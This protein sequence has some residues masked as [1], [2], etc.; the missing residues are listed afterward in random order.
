MIFR[1]WR[2]LWGKSIRRELVT[3][4]ALIYL[5]SMGLYAAQVGSRQRTFLREKASSRTEVQAT[6][7]ATAC[8][9]GVM[10]NDLAGLQEI[11]RAFIREKDVLYAM[12]IDPQGRVLAHSDASKAGLYLTDPR[13]LEI[14]KSTPKPKRI[15]SSE[16][17]IEYAAPV[18]LGP[19]TLGWVRIARDLSDDNAHLRSLVLVA[20]LYTT[21]AVVIGTALTSLLAGAIL[22]PLQLLLSGAERISQ[23]RLDER[24]PITTK[25]EVGTVSVAFN[26]AMHRLSIQIAERARAEE[27][28]RSQTNRLIEEV[29]VLATA[30]AEIQNTA[31]VLAE[32]AT[33]TATAVVETTTSVEEI[34]QM[35]R[36][37]SNRAQRVAQGAESAGLVSTAGKAAADAAS[38]GM[39]RIRQQ[40][41]AIAASMMG[42]SE[43]TRTIGEIV[44]TVD[45]LSQHS[46]LLAVNAAIEA[47][48]AGE[49]GRGFA[50]V[51]SE[52][53]NLATQSRKATTQVRSILAEIQ[54]ATSAAV[55]ATEQGTKVVELGASQSAQAGESIHTLSDSISTAVEA[56]MQ[57]A[58]S[59]RQQ[60]VGMDQVAGAM[61]SVKHASE[62]NVD[63]ATELHTSVRRLSELGQRL[64]QLVEQYKQSA[65]GV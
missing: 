4:F 3:G 62:Q 18:V 64:T 22:R 63:G 43:Q 54:K 29:A 24:I 11:L 7:L 6:L 45:V 27:N 17:S 41:D 1:A 2:W 23:G 48:R 20:I 50:I 28:L 38:E 25:N 51:A 35:S 19:R 57:I 44:A 37:A 36:E 34:R 8:L 56:A 61:K 39:Q 15:L 47:A 33:G 32:N 9:P 65:G 26:Q 42:L 10:S 12:A 55:L 58:S 5:V 46:N 21:A 30:A 16:N 52:I 49:V 31:K 14:L 40:M 60:L 59:S 13:S 53:R